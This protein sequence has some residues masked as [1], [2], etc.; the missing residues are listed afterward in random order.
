MARSKN[1]NGAG[2]SQRQLRVGELIRRTLSTVLARAEVHDPVLNAMSITV[3]EVRTSS[4]LKIATVY[5]MPL[6]GAGKEEAI[7]ALVRNKFE[8]RR[9]LG[10]DL[11]LKYLPDLR[12][13]IDQTFDQ[14]DATREMLSRAEVRRDVEL[15]RPED[16]AGDETGDGEDQK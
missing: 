1:Q 13:L 4:D 3:G 7:E 11:K 12:F 6:G 8:L 9:L 10:K 16:D 2:K 14:M 15:V 5:V